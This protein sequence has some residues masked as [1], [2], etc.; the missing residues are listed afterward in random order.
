M[1]NAR[2]IDSLSLTI[3]MLFFLQIVASGVAKTLQE[4][5]KYIKCTFLNECAQAKV[6]TSDDLAII[7]GE[8]AARSATNA[9]IDYLVKNDFIKVGSKRNMVFL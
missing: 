3:E 4:I 6:L 1:S 9:C 2:I 5:E 7:K 8:S